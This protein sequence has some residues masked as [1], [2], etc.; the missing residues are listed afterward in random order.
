L[1]H[2]EVRRKEPVTAA[3]LTAGTFEIDIAGTRVPTQVS[4]KPFFDPERSRILC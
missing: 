1:R 3:A 4:L 2:A